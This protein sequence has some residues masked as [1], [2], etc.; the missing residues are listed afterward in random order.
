MKATIRDREALLSIRPLDLVAYLRANHWHESEHHEGRY[1]IWLRNG[2]GEPAEILLP[3]NREYRDYATRIAEAL[4]TLAA[5]EERNQV[6][7]LHDIH[8]AIPIIKE[9]AFALRESSS[10]EDF[11]LEGYV[12]K[13]EKLSHISR[14]RITVNGLIDDG[15]RYVLV[16][17]DEH[18]YW[19]ATNAHRDRLLVR[20]DGE[21]IREGRQYVLRNARLF[22][23]VRQD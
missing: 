19:Q 23:V 4:Q 10:R 16:E 11:H 1:A 20:C 9:A 2:Q 12:V 22:E 21:L 7:I 5:V 14:G 18:D 15:F 8:L 17:L 13:L 3:L 6:D